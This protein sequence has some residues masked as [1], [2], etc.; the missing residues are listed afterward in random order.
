MF[1]VIKILAYIMNF[2]NQGREYEKWKAEREA[3]DEARLNRA[4]TTDGEWRREW[5]S[6]KLEQGQV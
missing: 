4:R 2:I 1:L 3:I 6:A 5:D